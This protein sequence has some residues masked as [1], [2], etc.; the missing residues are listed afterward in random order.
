MLFHLLDRIDSWQ[1]GRAATGRK[2]TSAAET[3][4]VSEPFGRRTMPP[5]LV[6]EVACQTASWLLLLG[7]DFRQRA[8][9]LSV[10]EVC[11]LTP[12]MPGDELVV[13]VAISAQTD[14]AAVLEATVRVEGEPVLIATGIMCALLAAEALDDPAA[15]E[16]MGRTLCREE[17]VA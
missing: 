14:E 16:R 4:W 1:A 7:S 5:G 10:D 11:H 13:T 6:L 9:L 3:Y 17:L 8:A 15:T 12:V 2:F